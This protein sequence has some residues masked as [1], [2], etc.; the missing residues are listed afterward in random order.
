[1]HPQPV[2]P[3]PPLL[4][5]TWQSLCASGLSVEGRD[6]LQTNNITAAVAERFMGEIGFAHPKDLAVGEE[7][8]GAL[9]GGRGESAL[10]GGR[11]E[12][13]VANDAP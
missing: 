5:A 13:I 7:G 4:Q 10:G 8:G 9:G 6:L 11:G 3:P 2:P 1:M 12:R